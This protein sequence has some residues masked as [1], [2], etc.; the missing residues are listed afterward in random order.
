MS[1]SIQCECGR[2][3]KARD[4]FAGTRGE[5]P[6]C[7]R[8]LVIPE[9]A[10]QTAPT[11]AAIGA[12]AAIFGEALHT[13]AESRNPARPGEGEPMEIVD[14]LDPPTRPAPAGSKRKPITMRAMFEALLDPR[15][16]QWMLMLGGGLLVLGA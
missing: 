2:K 13:R 5:C 16:I 14:Y 11:E 9:S 15:S 12:T 4:G 10:D 1:I 7:G 3:L 6:T 8:T